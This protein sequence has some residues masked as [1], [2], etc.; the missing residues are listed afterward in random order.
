MQ[1]WANYFRIAKKVDELISCEL[2]S[3]MLKP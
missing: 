2:S 1:H 3:L